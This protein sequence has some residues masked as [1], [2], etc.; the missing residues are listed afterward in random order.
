MPH[1]V[2]K[3]KKKKM[4]AKKNHRK[5]NPDSRVFKNFQRI[6]KEGAKG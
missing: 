3:N 6:V 2:N 1:F 4:V 5:P